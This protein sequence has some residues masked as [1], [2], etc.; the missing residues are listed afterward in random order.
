MGNMILALPT[1]SD[2]AAIT[3][4]SAAATMEAANLQSVQPGD[5][6]RATDLSNAW[7]Q[8]D[9][10]AAAAVRMIW[11]GYT[12]AS[13]SA[14]WRVRAANTLADLTGSPAYDSGWIAHRVGNTADWE[15]THAFLWLTVAI[16]HPHWRIDID[17]E[18]NPDGWYEAGRLYLADPWQP[19]RNRRYGAA[20]GYADDS[21]AERARGGQTYV[22]EGGQWREGSF[23]LG[24]M[25]REEMQANAA[26]IDRLVGT[27]RD[28][29]IVYDPDDTGRLMDECFYARL[30][31]LRPLLLP[32]HRLYEKSYAFAE[33]ELP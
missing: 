1:V 8:I 33:W 25:D 30:T 4:G 13:A 21:S 24:F 12:N 3:A 5:R 16:A 27:R 26:R 6:W 11:L 9:L 31:E 28:L 15:R 10:G 17:D 22:A 29:L 20:D 14:L 2:R 18:D 19:S 32:H 23:T 7:L